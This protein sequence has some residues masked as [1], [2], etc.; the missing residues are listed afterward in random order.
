MPDEVKV[1]HGL[2]TAVFRSASRPASG[3]PYA[4]SS[5]VIELRADGLNVERLVFMYTFSWGT[6]AAFFD[7]LAASWRGW[8]GERQWESPECDLAISAISDALGHNMLQ[9]VV[10]DGPDGSWRTQVEGFVLAAGEET[11]RAAT[12]VREW[13]TGSA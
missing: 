9:I 4:G 2:P 5:F 8:D 1:G 6:L 10:R 7:G 3:D 12:S 11:A 13:A